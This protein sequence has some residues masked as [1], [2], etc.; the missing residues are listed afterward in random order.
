MYFSLHSLRK[1]QK[2]LFLLSELAIIA[3]ISILIF[4]NILIP[5]DSDYAMHIYE[6]MASAICGWMAIDIRNLYT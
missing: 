3:L 5:S 4:G 6:N 2:V 1:N